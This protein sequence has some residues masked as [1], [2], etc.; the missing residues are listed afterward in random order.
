[1]EDRPRP[2]N[3]TK[4]ALGASAIDPYHCKTSIVMSNMH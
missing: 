3:H 2:T 4:R 1:M